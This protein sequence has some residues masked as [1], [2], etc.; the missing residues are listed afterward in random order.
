MS[1]AN[2]RLVDDPYGNDDARWAAVAARDKSADGAF[3]SC[4][5]TTGVY[6]L[7]SCAGRPLRKNVSFARTRAE[8]ERAG[9]RP[10]KRCHPDRLVTGPLAHR[11]ASIDWARVLTELD[12]Q[13]HAML[14]SLLSE[15]ECAALIA[16]YDS[17]HYRSTVAMRRHGFGEGDYRY[18]SDAPPALVSGLREGLY[19]H[20]VPIAEKWAAALG[21]PCS[22]PAKLAD[23]RK[24]CAARGQTRPTP[25]ILKY[26]AG[27]YN[28][29]HQDL[30]GEEVFP[31]Q[32]AI[33]LSEPGKDFD[34]GEFV[35]TEQRP[36]M[37][38][39]A[40]VVPLRQ[41]EAAAFAV[42]DRPVE[43]ARGVYRAKMRHGVATIRS[44]ARFTLG[45]IF[46]D[47]P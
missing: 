5:A 28:R 26:G 3:Y 25:L 20:F 40:E 4:V 1:A 46:H 39:R 32:V 41:G 24:E 19:P 16:A 23:Y 44:G 31:V 27:G 12:T 10:C 47:A 45:I 9:F 11:I 13:G 22:F 29:L 6:C 33:L 7:P 17:D 2:L 34:G 18:F 43:G 8:A 42:N 15:E 21:A 38:S 30:Y 14:G 35:L 36:R 37:Q